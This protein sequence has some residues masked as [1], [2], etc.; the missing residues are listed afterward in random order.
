M[1][2]RRRKASRRG[3]VA[4]WTLI[5]FGTILAINPGQT[6]SQIGAVVWAAGVLVQLIIVARWII[7]RPSSGAPI[8]NAKPHRVPA[9]V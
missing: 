9:H 5:W 7:G 3:V 4:A 1:S 8:T 2:S 6:L